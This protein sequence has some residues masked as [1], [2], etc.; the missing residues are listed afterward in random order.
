M[1]QQIQVNGIGKTVHASTIAEILTEEGVDD[2]TPFLAVALNGSVV[3]RRE[4][5]AAQL[6]AGDSVEIVKPVSGG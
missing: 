2:S 3:P 5:Q 6:N 4:W 1:S